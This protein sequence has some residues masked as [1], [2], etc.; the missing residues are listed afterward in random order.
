MQFVM[1]IR[2]AARVESSNEVRAKLGRD[3]AILGDLQGPKI[4]I[5]RFKDGSIQLEEGDVF[6]L[7]AIKT[8]NSRPGKI[9]F[10]SVDDF[11][12][13]LHISSFHDISFLIALQFMKRSGLSVPENIGIIAI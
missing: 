13:T 2:R 4:R 5:D 3:V 11:K 8:P 6:I 10:F 1:N 12:E 7:D 9:H